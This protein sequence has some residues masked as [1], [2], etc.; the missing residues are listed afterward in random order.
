ME[1]K[2]KRVSSK[3]VAKLWINGKASRNSNNQFYSPDGTTLYS[4]GKHY[5]VAHCLPKQN[6]VLVNTTRVS[7]TTSKHCSL[8]RREI[9][10]SR[11]VEVEDLTAKLPSIIERDFYSPDMF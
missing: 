1:M 3:E 8:A 5:V 4:Y 6:I 2:M 11:I 10:A 7:P 9:P